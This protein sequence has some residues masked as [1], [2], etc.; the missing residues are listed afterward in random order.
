MSLIAELKIDR[1]YCPYLTAL[2]AALG[3]AAAIPK[4]G[5]NC[6][7]MRYFLELLCIADP[8]GDLGRISLPH[9]YVP[10]RHGVRR[11]RCARG[12]GR[13]AL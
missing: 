11:E 12:G 1:V 5:V 7:N 2:E 4:N 8:G 9:G 13:G 3:T 10:Y 6:S